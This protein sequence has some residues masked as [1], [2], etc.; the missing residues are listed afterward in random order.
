MELFCAVRGLR[1]GSP[2]TFQP[3]YLPAAGHANAGQ[4]KEWQGCKRHVLQAL[5]IDP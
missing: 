4:Y 1:A 5:L 3:E 2:K